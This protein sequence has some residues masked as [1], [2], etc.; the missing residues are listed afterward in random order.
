MIVISLIT[1][2]QRDL[3]HQESKMA[4]LD[5]LARISAFVAPEIIL[6]RILPFMLVMV[7]DAFPSVRAKAIGGES[8]EL[9]CGLSP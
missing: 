3:R 8:H 9:Y 5:L 6:D 7:S 1:S 2:A 4:A